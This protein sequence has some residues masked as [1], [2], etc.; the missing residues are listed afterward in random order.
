MRA[1]D[2]TCA[3]E[4]SESEP[5]EAFTW[6]ATLDPRDDTL[7]IEITDEM[8]TLALAE[9]EREQ[10]YP[11]RREADAP[12]PVARPVRKAEVI[13]FPRASAARVPEE[14]R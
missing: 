14:R 10:V 1:S 8:I 2:E 5:P 4:R 6:A 7:E 12:P 11:F 9:I 13:P 3:A